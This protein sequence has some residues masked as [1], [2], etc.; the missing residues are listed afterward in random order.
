MSS[1][2]YSPKCVTNVFMI[3]PCTT[4]VEPMLLSTSQTNLLAIYSGSKGHKSA[5]T[6][7]P[8]KFAQSR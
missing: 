8:V 2:L 6:R 4:T 7:H 5:S 1:V 3:R